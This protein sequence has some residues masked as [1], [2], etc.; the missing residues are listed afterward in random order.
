[1]H[2][3]ANWQPLQQPSFGYG[4]NCL[5]KDTK[6]LLVNNG[7]VPENLIMAIVEANSTRKDYIADRVLQKS[8]SYTASSAWDARQ[9]K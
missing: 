1:L 7:D 5:L 3:S 4:G 2:G 9:E 6:Q 8:G